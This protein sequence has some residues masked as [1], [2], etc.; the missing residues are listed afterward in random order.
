M[1]NKIH[2]LCDY[3]IYGDISQLTVYFSTSHADLIYDSECC[4]SDHVAPTS[5][6]ATSSHAGAGIVKFVLKSF[7]IKCDIPSYVFEELDLNTLISV[8]KDVWSKGT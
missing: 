8:P 3:I 4:D 2:E 1:A 6:H 5:F 7:K